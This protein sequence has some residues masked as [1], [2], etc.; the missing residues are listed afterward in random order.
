MLLFGVY[1]RSVLTMQKE[2]FSED[3]MKEATA[4]LEKDVQEGWNSILQKMAGAV[5]AVA[6]A[7]VAAEAQEVAQANMGEVE[8]LL[9]ALKFLASCCRDLRAVAAN[10]KLRAQLPILM[11]HGVKY[12]RVH[13]KRKIDSGELTL[14]KTKKWVRDNVE[15]LLLPAMKKARTDQVGLCVCNLSIACA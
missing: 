13:F 10:L 9:D 3:E 5:A 2:A 6:A 15:G 7:S 11:E 14:E 4:A 1:T 12:E 8:V